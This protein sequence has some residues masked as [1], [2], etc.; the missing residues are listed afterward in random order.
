ME[1]LQRIR[2]ERPVAGRAAM[3]SRRSKRSTPPVASGGLTGPDAPTPI[4]F[5]HLRV[6]VDR[7]G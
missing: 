5:G 6:G 4:G 7:P 3:G 2:S 1:H